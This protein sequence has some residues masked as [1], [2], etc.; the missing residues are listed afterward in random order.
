MGRI[1]R[2][3]EEIESDIETQSKVCCVCDTR[4][5]FSDFYNYKNKNDGKSYRCK[6]CDNLARDKW[7]ENNPE[8]AYRSMR[9]RNLRHQYGI[10]ITEY[11]EL[12]E[13]QGGCCAICGA[14]ENSTAGSR[15]EWNFSVDH[16][17]TTGEIRGLL[18]NNCNRGLGLL[19][20]TYESVQK[21]AEYL[22]KRS[23]K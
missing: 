2:T 10:G 8:S 17:H 13:K 21:A 15:K 12:L 7:R 16:D 3:K 11:E 19:G 4:K 20:D 23:N 6:C 1:K 18:C 5:P 9:G 22:K 14:T